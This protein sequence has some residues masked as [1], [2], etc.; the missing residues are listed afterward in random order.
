MTP[1]TTSIIT[2]IRTGIPTIK[3]T[4]LHTLQSV[5]KSVTSVLMG[6][7]IDEGLISGVKAPALPYFQSYHSDPNEEWKTS[8]AIEDLLTMRSGIRWDETNYDLATNSCILMEN[9]EDWIGYVLQQPMDAEP[10]TQFEYNSGASVLLGK[11]V[12]Q[13]TGKRIDQWAEEKLFGPL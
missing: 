8:L 9:S 2:I 4:D 1:S 5:T 3:N 12:R 13:A 7:A 10:G 6:I 11:I